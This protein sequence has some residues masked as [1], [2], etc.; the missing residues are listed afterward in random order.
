MEVS[1]FRFILLLIISN[2][3]KP[4]TH[5]VKYFLFQSIASIIFLLSSVIILQHQNI[6][7]L[8]ILIKL[9]AAPFHL[10]LM[11]IINKISFL[12]LIW[13][14]VIQ[15][16][17]PLRLI[18]FITWNNTTI[19]FVILRYFLGVIHIIIQT[20]LIKIVIASSIYSTPW[21][22]VAFLTEESLGWIF[23]VS[24]SVLQ[25]IFIYL[26]NK[27]FFIPIKNTRL[28]RNIYDSFILICI[29]FLRGFPPRPLFF[30]KLKI[31]GLILVYFRL[32]LPV[33][34]VI[35]AR[36]VIFTYLNIVLRLFTFRPA[37]FYQ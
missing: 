9:G 22:I 6:I 8:I 28:T 4:S 20:K 25:V 7:L 30:F 26:V 29:L 23:F 33:I 19:F 24:Y 34:F 2:L 5:P 16:I 37:K 12:S 36:V 13:L 31:L 18:L 17:I 35:G 1:I 14:S 21:V 27:V 32:L 15:K 3:T 11:A 10:W